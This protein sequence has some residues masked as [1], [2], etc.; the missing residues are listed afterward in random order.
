MSS[1]NF[2]YLINFGFIALFLYANISGLPILGYILISVAW[3]SIGLGS[4]LYSSKILAKVIAGGG[5]IRIVPYWMSIITD[6]IIGFLF[7]YTGYVFL[8]FAWFMQAMIQERAYILAHR[9]RSF[10]KSGKVD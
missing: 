10:I 2:W 1:S 8:S 9:A 7:L 5:L 4:L 6:I 3:V